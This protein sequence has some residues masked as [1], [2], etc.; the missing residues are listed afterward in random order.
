MDERNLKLKN[1]FIEMMLLVGMDNNSGLFPKELEEGNS[2]TEDIFSIEYQPKVLDCFCS[3]TVRHFYPSTW[4]EILLNSQT[5][6]LKMK[7]KF[8]TN[9]TGNNIVMPK[10]VY[11]TKRTKPTINQLSDE[12]IQNIAVFCFPDGAKLS[13]QRTDNF[14]VHYFVLTD[15][16]GVRNYATC[17]TFHR[18][19]EATKE[20]KTWKLKPFEKTKLHG[21]S[22][23]TESVIVYVPHACAFVSTQPYFTVMKQCLSILL[24][25]IKLTKDIHTQNLLFQEFVRQLCITPLPPAGT[26]AVGVHL[27][28][29][30]V[31]LRPPH[32]SSIPVLDLS[33]HIVFQCFPIE[34]IIQIITCILTEKRIVFLSSNYALLT[35]VTESL[36]SL[37][38]P[39]SWRHTYVPLVSDSHLELLEAPGSFIMG[40]HLKHLPTVK[41]IA[42]LVMVNIDKG[43]IIVNELEPIF[44][45][46]SYT[47]VINIP[48][49]PQEPVKLLAEVYEK[50]KFSFD[51]IDL[52][53]P[54]RFNRKEELQ[55]RF[56]KISSFNKRM[57]YAFVE[58]M[59]NLFRD[60]APE[61]KADLKCFK[62]NNFLQKQLPANIPFYT[63]VMKTTLFQE[64]LDNILSKKPSFWSELELKTRTLSRKSGFSQNV[65]VSNAHSMTGTK[66]GLVST[67]IEELPNE[68][69]FF[70]PSI[71]NAVSCTE[72]LKDCIKVCTEKLQDCRHFSHRTS[73]TYLRGMYSYAGSEYRLAYED[74]KN[75]HESAESIYISPKLIHEASSKIP[76]YDRHDDNLVLEETKLSEYISQTIDNANAVTLP[77]QNIE[78][79]K[80]MEL[81]YL[82]D[83]CQSYKIRKCIFNILSKQESFVNPVVLSLFLKSWQQNCDQCSRLP[84]HENELVSFEWFLCVSGLIKTS[85]GLGHLVLTNRRLLFHKLGA[86]TLQNL[87]RMQQIEKV[88]KVNTYSIFSQVGGL[89]IVTKDGQKITANLKKQQEMWYL[90]LCEM[91][92]AKMYSIEQKENDA[93]LIGAETVLVLMALQNC[94]SSLQSHFINVDQVASNMCC[95]FKLKQAGCLKLSKHTADVLQKKMNPNI[96]NGCQTVVDILYIPKGER[97]Q[98]WC[99]LGNGVVR[100]F[101]ANEWELEK[102]FVQTNQTV[103]CL[104]SPSS[105]QIWAGCVNILIINTDH[106]NC[107]MKLT[108]HKDLVTAIIQ[109]ESTSY[110]FSASLDGMIHKWDVNS[111]VLV[112]TIKV[113]IEEGLKN[114]KFHDNLIWCV[115]KNS[116]LIVDLDGVAIKAVKPS[117]MLK[118]TKDAE[119]MILECFHI[120]KP[121]KE[122]W[123]GY[124]NTNRILVL[125]SETY[126]IK[127]TISLKFDSTIQSGITAIIGV[128]DMLWIAT[129]EGTIHIYNLYSH[130]KLLVLEGHNDAIYCLHVTGDRYI[131][132]GAG[133]A[134]SKIAVWRAHMLTPV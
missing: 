43:T 24:N 68:F 60:I 31:I 30:E 27:S 80:F 103:G 61:C 88:T 59:V 121:T 71:Y 33:L 16:L 49:M 94:K 113:T 2:Q 17:L 26:L 70:I 20:R 131:F 65:F 10:P 52:E 78:F 25:K 48:M 77:D 18:K 127:D 67:S 6:D 46:M 99:A 129:K 50:V 95:Y 109:A 118:T 44:G 123:L 11:F 28:G 12:D 1:S 92:A 37:I 110:A 112:K 57:Q 55:F 62:Q 73:L 89:Q 100:V 8:R 126:E 15:F 83:I 13:A 45:A 101:D 3:N 84:R 75:L 125:D 21:N 19:Y 9:P 104:F 91:W 79:Q 116:L 117:C 128:K 86:N 76:S 47:Y 114:I 51:F 22:H 82:L 74:L 53:S 90:I 81:L 29:H 41:Q 106:I 40:C 130:Q 42:D 72:Y 4:D 7:E 124:L 39:F 120:V 115:S 96:D 66:Q 87:C 105:H 58:L 111:L 122:I 64:F 23:Y 133:S 56:Q 32:H 35:I 85:C 38:Y 119:A 98:L 36:C 5:M 63:E 54:C 134:D 107:V 102:E 108:A 97:S 132:S 93:I 69:I 34:T 14:K